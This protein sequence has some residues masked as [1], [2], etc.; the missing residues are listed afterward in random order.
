MT[1][2]DFADIVRTGGM[3]YNGS[4]ISW[5][6]SP[7]RNKAVGGHENSFHMMWLAADLV[8]DDLDGIVECREF[9]KRMD[10]S[11]KLNGEFGLT[12]HV[13]VVAPR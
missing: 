4:V 10:L 8:F 13:Q 11:T 2:G 7:T 12:L 5:G 3:R 9:Y 6:R 1:F